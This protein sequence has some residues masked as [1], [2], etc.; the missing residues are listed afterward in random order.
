VKNFLTTTDLSFQQLD[1]LL[2]SAARVKAGADPRRANMALG[3]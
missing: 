3:A 2:K 1:E